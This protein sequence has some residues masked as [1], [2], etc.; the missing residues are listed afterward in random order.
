MFLT[1]FFNWDILDRV[2]C[3]D[4]EKY[5]PSKLGSIILR[6]I[7]QELRKKLGRTYKIENFL[8]LKKRRFG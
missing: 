1:N 5:R 6:S 7:R 3:I 2:F 8:F 4:L